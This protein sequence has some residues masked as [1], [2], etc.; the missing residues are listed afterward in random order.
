MTYHQNSENMFLSYWDSSTKWPRWC[1]Q[2][3][4]AILMLKWT[5]LANNKIYLENSKIP[6]NLLYLLKDKNCKQLY[7]LH[8]HQLSWSK[9]YPV[10]LYLMSSFEILKHLILSE[11]C[12]S[13]LKQKCLCKFLHSKCS[14]RHHNKGEET[15][16]VPGPGGMFLLD[17]SRLGELSE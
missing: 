8:D 9:D 4:T 17:C 13:N 6:L 16:N 7:F 3:S 14:P 11:E 10:N 5:S 15:E 1:F 12:W 2:N